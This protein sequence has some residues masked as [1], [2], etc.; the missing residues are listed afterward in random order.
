MGLGFLGDGALVDST[1]TDI[2]LLT[3]SLFRSGNPRKA[4]IELRGPTGEENG[5]EGQVTA[6]P[7]K[8]QLGREA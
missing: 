4:L 1:D 2:I 7:R 6:N 5:D 8:T 3:F